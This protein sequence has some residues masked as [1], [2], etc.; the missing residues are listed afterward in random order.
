MQ[1]QA[2]RSCARGAT[3][4]SNLAR[5]ACCRT[6]NPRTLCRAAEVDEGESLPSGQT[7]A[8]YSV[9]KGSS[10][11]QVRRDPRM[12]GRGLGFRHTGSPGW[13]GGA[14]GL[15]MQGARVD[16]GGLGLCMQGAQRG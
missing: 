11:L 14:W 9:Y 6:L 10:A 13:L 15:C 1:A 16:G 8:H 4:H 3:P 12:V 2:S 7:Y 5:A